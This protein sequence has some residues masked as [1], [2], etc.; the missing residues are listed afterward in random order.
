NFTKRTARILNQEISLADTNVVFVDDID[1]DAQA[2][3]VGRQR[4]DPAL[5]QVNR[6]RMTIDDDPVII[7]IRR[8]AAVDYLQC[9]VPMPLPAGVGSSGVDPAMAAQLIDGMQRMMTSTCYQAR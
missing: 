7:A 1:R 2:R 3:I 5:P 8:A 9:D 6:D 4:I